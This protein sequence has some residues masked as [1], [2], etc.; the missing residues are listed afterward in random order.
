MRAVHS[1]GNS[2]LRVVRIHFWEDGCQLGLCL[3]ETLFFCLDI[4]VAPIHSF[5][6][7]SLSLFFSWGQHFLFS[8]GGW[9]SPVGKDWN[10]GDPLGWNGW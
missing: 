3:S 9:T 4:S 10:M 5:C 6:Q 8:L 7:A 2:C 1:R